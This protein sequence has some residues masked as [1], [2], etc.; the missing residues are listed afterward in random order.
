MHCG[1]RI[2]HMVCLLQ[3]VKDKHDVPGCAM[4]VGVCMYCA[5]VDGE[6]LCENGGPVCPCPL[7]P[8]SLMLLSTDESV[9]KQPLWLIAAALVS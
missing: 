7:S 8:A 2:R 4:C 6:K 1:L 9:W 3:N 5:C